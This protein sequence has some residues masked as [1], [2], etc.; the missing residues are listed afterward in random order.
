VLWAA[1]VSKHQS[2]RRAGLL[3][4]TCDC[5]GRASHFSEGCCEAITRIAKTLA[6]LDP[7]SALIFGNTIANY[8]LGDV[9]RR[10]VLEEWAGNDPEGFLAFVESAEP[11]DIRGA[12]DAFAI[13]AAMQPEY[14]LAMLDRIPQSARTFRESCWRQCSMTP[15]YGV[16]ARESLDR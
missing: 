12:G 4:D 8:D 10:S 14:L 6:S 11:A 16:W 7:Q 2:F 3:R 15:E 13:A 5:W 1:L 9:F